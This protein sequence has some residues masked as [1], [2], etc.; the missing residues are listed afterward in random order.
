MLPER[1]IKEKIFR[2]TS[3]KN[4]YSKQK[5]TFFNTCIIKYKFNKDTFKPKNKPIRSHRNTEKCK[6][7]LVEKNFPPKIKLISFLTTSIA[8]WFFRHTSVYCMFDV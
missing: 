3:E 6:W 5:Q 2:K 7:G 1:F 8:Q 4:E